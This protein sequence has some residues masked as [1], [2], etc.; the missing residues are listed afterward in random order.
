MQLKPLVFNF[1]GVGEG[2]AGV[3]RVGGGGC[4]AVLVVEGGG[5]TTTARNSGALV[6]I[7]QKW[8]LYPLLCLFHWLQI[9]Q[10][11]NFRFLPRFFSITVLGPRTVPDIFSIC[12]P[13]PKSDLPLTP[14]D[15]KPRSPVGMRIQ[16]NHIPTLKI[17]E[18]KTEFGGLWKHSN[19]QACNI[20]VR[21][22]RV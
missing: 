22:L 5:T 6:L 1:F 12:I 21:I 19:N 9:H 2:R 18:A 15:Y 11:I 16:R 10:R 20:C 4:G 14:Y 7:I 8:H 17:L 3:G 13:S